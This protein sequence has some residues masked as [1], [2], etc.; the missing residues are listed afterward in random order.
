[1]KNVDRAPEAVLRGPARDWAAPAGLAGLIRD[2]ASRTPHAIAV[3]DD[4]GDLSYAALDLASDAIAARLRAAGGRPGDVVAVLMPRG[5][6]LPA[7][8]LGAVK[9]GMPYLPVALDD[10]PARRDLLLATSGARYALAGQDAARLLAGRALTVLP[11]P[12]VPADPA[13]LGAAGPAPLA[14]YPAGHP[15][16]VLFTSGTTGAPKGAVIPSGALVNRLLWMCG[17]FSFGPGDRILQKTPYTF[18]V[19]GWELWCPLLAGATL[20]MLAPGAHAD[21]ALVAA[22]ITER[23]ITACHFVPSMLAEFLRWPEAARCTS[24]RAVF[25]SGEELT[26]GLASRFAAVLGARLYNLYGPTEAAID[27]SWWACPPGAGRTLIGG[28]VPN[29]TLAVVAGDLSPVPS[30]ETGELAIGGL[31][32]AD[33]YLGQPGLTARSFVAAPAW[34]GVRRLYLT[35]DLVRLRRGGLE[36][37]GR[38]DAQVKIRG[39][40]VE[41]AAVEDALAALPGVAR[42]AATTVSADRAADEGSGGGELCA[43]L[44]AGDDGAC[45]DARQVRAKLGAALP[46]S[47]V[48]THVWRVSELPLSPSGKLARRQVAALAAGLAAGRRGA[49]PADALARLWRAATGLSP[50]DLSPASEDTGFLDA[51]GHSLAAARLAAG[52]LE[53][54]GVRLP[55]AEI[56]TGNLSLAGLR[57]RLAGVPEAGPAAGGTSEQ[58]PRPQQASP[59]QLSPQQHGLWVWSRLHPDCPAYNVRAALALDGRADPGRLRRAVEGLV[60]RHPALRLTITGRG[61]PRSWPASDAVPQVVTGADVAGR[62]LDQ[63]FRPDALPRLAVG[64]QRPPGGPD[65]LLVALDHLI[66]DQRALDIV[67]GDLAALY[68]GRDPGPP[69][70]SAPEAAEPDDLDYW[71]GWLDGAPRRLELPFRRARPAVTTLRGGSC[72]IALGGELTGALRAWC[73]AARVTPFAAVLAVFARQLGLWCGVDDL[74]IGVPVSVRRSAAEQ[75]AVGNFA[76]TLP[77]RLAPGALDAAGVTAVA[78][79]LYEAA[80]HPGLAFDELVARLGGP[81]TL[82]HNPVFQVWCNDVSQAQVPAALGDAPVTADW[83]ADRW[84]LF[85]AGLYLCP[86]AGG[87]LR[88]RLA[89][90]DD[91]W[92]AVTASEFLAQCAAAL[93]DAVSPVAPPPDRRARE[94]SSDPE[95]GGASGPPPE[96]AA[97]LTAQV[98]AR[99]AAEPAREALTGCGAGGLRRAI[100]QVS[101]AVRRHGPVAGVIARRDPGFAAAVLG[102]WRAGVAPLLID[103]ALPPAARSAALAA[104]RAA[105]LIDP[106]PEAATAGTP[107]DGAPQSGA[108]QSEAPQSGT[109]ENEIA[110]LAMSAAW[111]DAAPEDKEPPDPA[112]AG[113]AGHLLLTSGT[114]GAPAVVSVPAGALPALLRGYAAELGLTA[115]D[116]FGWTVPPAHDPVFRDLFLPL[117]L[118]AP[119][120]VPAPADLGP[121]RLAGWLADSGVTVLHLTPTQAGLLAAAGRVL[122]AL[123]TVVCHGET[124]RGGTVAAL[125]RLAPGARVWNCYG[126]TETPQAASLHRVVPGAAAG[127][128]GS[129]PASTTPTGAAPT[130]AAPT[131]AV[132]I[133]A[134]APLRS[135]RVEGPGGERGTGILGEIVVSGAGLACPAGA[136]RPPGEY[137]TGDLG[138]LRPDGLIDIA[139]RADRQ[140]SVGG[141]RVQL[142]GIEA[143]LLELPGVRAAH[144][145]PDPATGRPLAWW[146][147]R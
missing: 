75:D 26:P 39:Q 86:A 48:P 37:L 97:D 134:G 123:R 119:V 100:L 114:S 64:V 76:R 128:S 36:F 92:D 31:P 107:E 25:C 44:V 50:A 139:G 21:P 88:L 7:A 47:H 5:R 51:G 32:L 30:G 84:S 143:V 136:A 67:L 103:P 71:L 129:G 135:V 42:A 77:V 23:R 9:A 54:Y 63:V 19:S 3:S 1:M 89:Y 15:V 24:L 11:V 122:P 106:A 12:A 118:G 20:V 104:A 125:A 99:C 120:R 121:G 38:R 115:G 17:E 41:L 27:V 28:P 105:V 43:L 124:L 61:Q 18:D 101:A 57:A 52:V 45:P 131:G 142:D 8:L 81:R 127:F 94:P 34:T 93:R 113:Q 87:G 79:A 49:E 13:G 138:R 35:G 126:T 62:V 116:V 29:C 10:P 96:V 110:A 60:R 74:V 59:R 146:S 137:R 69:P 141:Y 4:T 46:A 85:D 140:V 14:A 70:Q 56:I 145:A 65:T 66:A 6:A 133:G 73:A 130:G 91:V 33:G 16:Y 53:R 147:G 111:R 40:R 78:A 144:A 95:R 98:L 112:G 72:D 83:P 102:C 22:C 55:L 117:L 90:G 82:A 109:P 108:P 2:V 58:R 68:D 132:P 80:E